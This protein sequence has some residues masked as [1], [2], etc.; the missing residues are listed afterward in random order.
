MTSAATP[1]RGLFARLFAFDDGALI[2]AAFFA[3]LTAAVAMVYLDYRELVASDAT[4]GALADPLQPLFPLLPGL[5]P[6]AS[7]GARPE[8]TTDRA[9]LDAPLTVSLKARG[10]LELT[11]TI[12][13]GALAR[14]T[15]EIAAHGEYVKTVALNSPGGSVEDALA[16]GRL[17][18]QHGYGTSVAA[19][20]LCASSCPLVLAAGVER[21]ADAKAAIGVHQVYASV[22]SADIPKGARAAGFGMSEAQK[23]TAT[24]S[25]YLTDMG[26]DP[27]LWL[28]A[29]DTPPESLYFLSPEEQRHFRLIT[30]PALGRA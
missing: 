14:V 5:N 26:V 4:T 11:G 29:L 28:H 22:L 24:V 19:G 8:I 18:R 25:R 27:A 23:M 30:R 9:L 20:A 12:D 6:G 15:D 13:P 21:T 10:L 3:L 1:R 7:T 17:I 16:I 2:R